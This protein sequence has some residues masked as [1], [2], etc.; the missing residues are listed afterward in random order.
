M[1]RRPRR[2]DDCRAGD[3]ARSSRGVVLCGVVRGVVRPVVRLVVRVLVRLVV[4]VLVRPV[5]VRVECGTSAAL[6]VACVG[7]LVAISGCA[8]APSADDAARSA[9]SRTAAASTP[10]STSPV[11]ERAVPAAPLRRLTLVTS[12]EGET[13]FRIGRDLADYVARP[14][15]LT[16][17][18]LPS[19]GGADN[20]HRLRD[21][22]D[23]DLAI[24]QYDVLQA[25]AEA[26]RA[27]NRD[28]ASLVRPLRIVAPLNTEEVYFIVRR[29]SPLHTTDDIRGARINVGPVGSGGAVTA[30]SLYR[31]MFGK[32][33]ARSRTSYLDEHAALAALTIDRSIDVAILIAGQPT[34]ALSRW[35]ADARLFIRLLPVDPAR[36]SSH[37]AY[38]AYFPATIRASS[39]PNWLADDVPTLSVLS[40]LVTSANRSDASARELDLFARSLCRNVGVLRERG[41]PKWREVDVTLKLAIGFG[42]APAS[43]TDLDRCP[44]RTA[45]A[46]AAASAELSTNLENRR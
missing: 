14:A 19:R 7:S 45:P 29:D 26:A 40:F 17:T 23:V 37:A 3:A 35:T 33:L 36:P 27:G 32:P 11:G 4:R 20:V 39:Y 30:A 28:A 41:H 12:E 10:M 1:R 15:G 13:D 8:R 21:S 5:M 42:Y 22:A 6:V 46:A 9:T 43:L 18:V 2:A 24:V 25:F 31:Q 16:L 34:G 44:P 38:R